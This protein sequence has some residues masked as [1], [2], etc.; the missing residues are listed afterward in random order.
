VHEGRPQPR[1]ELVE[2]AVRRWTQQVEVTDHR[3]SRR[4]RG[5]PPTRL[6]P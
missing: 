6:S 3:E 4:A 5:K 1:G 2:G